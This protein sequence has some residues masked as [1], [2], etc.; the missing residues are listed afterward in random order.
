MSF[1]HNTMCY[2]NNTLV[3]TEKNMLLEDAMMSSTIKGHS[4]ITEPS[5]EDSQ[6]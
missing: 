4:G 6:K 2:I 3:A 5:M 1:E